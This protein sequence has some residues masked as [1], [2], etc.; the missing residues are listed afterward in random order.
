M[1]N[2]T[3]TTKIYNNRTYHTFCKNSTVCL[4]KTYSFII[5]NI[6]III[7]NIN[8]KHPKLYMLSML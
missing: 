2:T 4:K 6:K 8:T 7:E 5:E 1:Q 3:V